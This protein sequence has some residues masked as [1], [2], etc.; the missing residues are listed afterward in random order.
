MSASVSG[1]GSNLSGA[2]L[3][4]QDFMKVLMAQLSYQNPLQPMDNQQFLAQIAQFTALGQTQEINTSLQT[5]MGNQASQQSIGLL[6]HTVT[7][8]NGSDQQS[9]TVT[10]IDLSGQTPRLTVNTASGPLPNVTMD[11]ILS[12]LR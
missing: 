4:L 11:Q 10:S 3:N 8:R 2:S 7:I 9:G 6:G 5:L 12:I 1:V